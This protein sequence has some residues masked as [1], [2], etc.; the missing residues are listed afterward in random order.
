[1]MSRSCRAPSGRWNLR[2]LA[3][4]GGA[5]RLRRP[6]RRVAAPPR[7]SALGYFVIAPSGNAVKHFFLLEIGVVMLGGE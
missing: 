1:M 4:Q 6:G 3:T 2:G 5:S 7:R